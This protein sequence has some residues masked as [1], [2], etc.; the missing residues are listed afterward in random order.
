M[1]YSKLNF[2]TIPYYFVVSSDF[3]WTNYNTILSIFFIIENY[4]GTIIGQSNS[5]SIRLDKRS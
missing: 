1:I 2:T 5:M 4:L 3:I